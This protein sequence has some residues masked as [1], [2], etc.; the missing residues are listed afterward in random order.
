M[1]IEFTHSYATFDADGLYRYTLGRYWVADARRFCNF[2][3][4]NPSTA[5]AEVLDPTVTRCVRYAHDWGFDGLIVTNIFALRATNPR[6]LRGVDDPVGPENRAAILSTAYRSE[7]VI[8][9]W[10][11]HGRFMGRGQIVAEQLMYAKRPEN[12]KCLG[13]TKHGYPRH[14]L[15]L[16]RDAQPELFQL[17][18]A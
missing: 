3:M 11:T 10:G 4:L 13:R 9:A 17:V 15:Y 16:R 1:D 14:P 12:L 18:A 7:L 2:V 8:A 6:D 5:D